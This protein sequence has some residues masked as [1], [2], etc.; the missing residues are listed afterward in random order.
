VLVC[1]VGLPLGVFGV[2]YFSLEMDKRDSI[3]ALEDYLDAM[4]DENYDAA[5]DMLC[6]K[7][8]TGVDRAKFVADADSAPRLVS[9]TI[10]D[11]TEYLD[12]DPDQVGYE[13]Y[14]V[15]TFDDGNT[16]DGAYLVYT[17]GFDVD[18]YHV[19]PPAG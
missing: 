13:V 19:C 3:S 4:R 11:A 7:S 12:G 17:E 14:V 16:D 10:G 2:G 1:C 18:S 9:Y 8:K 5:Y 15:T 6:D